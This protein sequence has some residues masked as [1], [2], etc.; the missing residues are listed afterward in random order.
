MTFTLRKQLAAFLLLV[1]VLLAPL[2]SFAHD[3][4]SGAADT[5]ACN[6]M[7]DDCGAD[8][9]DQSDGCPDTNGQKCCDCEDHCKQAAELSSLGDLNLYIPNKPIFRPITLVLIP[10]VYLAIFVPPQICSFG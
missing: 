1:A 5:C 6:M 2:T 8:E 10:E 9:G 4:A 7:P 3:A